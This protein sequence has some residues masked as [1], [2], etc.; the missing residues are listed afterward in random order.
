MDT[1][2]AVAEIK[3]SCDGRLAGI[4]IEED[5]ACTAGGIIGVLAT[6]L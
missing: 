4:L 2:K 5:G 1:G 6:V 3:S